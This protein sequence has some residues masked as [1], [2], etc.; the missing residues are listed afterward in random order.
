MRACPAQYG[1]L[2]N[3]GSPQN[4]YGTAFP[5]AQRH[6]LLRRSSNLREPGGAGSLGRSIGAGSLGGMSF[7]FAFG[8]CSVPMTATV[9]ARRLGSGRVGSATRVGSFFSR[10]WSRSRCDFPMMALRVTPNSFA[11]IPADQ[12]FDH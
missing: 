4:R 6:S 10:I 11:I 7:G 3:V 2:L 1:D 5:Y 12:F 8:M 9:P